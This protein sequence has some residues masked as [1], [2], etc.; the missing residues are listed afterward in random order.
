MMNDAV[1]ISLSSP[2]TCAKSDI[3][4]IWAENLKKTLNKDSKLDFRHWNACNLSQGCYSFKM[5][6]IYIDYSS[7]IETQGDVALSN[8]RTKPSIQRYQQRKKCNINNFYKHISPV[9]N[10]NTINCHVNSR[11]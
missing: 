10:K 8:N 7:Y 5:S 9:M 1:I 4:F 3:D 11:Q 6:H 2:C